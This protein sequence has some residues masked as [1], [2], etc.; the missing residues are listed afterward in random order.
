MISQFVALFPTKFEFLFEDFVTFIG[1]IVLSFV[2]IHK[3]LNR[4]NKNNQLMKE[5]AKMIKDLFSDE[6]KKMQLNAEI[7]RELRRMDLKKVND[8]ESKYIDLIF[9]HRKL[10]R[11][12]KQ[13]NEVYTRLVNSQSNYTSLQ[14]NDFVS[15]KDETLNSELS[16]DDYVYQLKRK[17]KTQNKKRM[18]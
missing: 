17:A 5:K 9:A 6:E 7:T 12:Y 15:V 16:W 11:E 3:L 4:L 8:S 14:E 1:C 2:I 10:K 13:L 18:L